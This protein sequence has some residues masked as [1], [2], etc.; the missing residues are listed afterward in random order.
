MKTSVIVALVAA[1]TIF[2]CIHAAN[3]R[4]K[5]D[6]SDG[7]S[8]DFSTDASDSATSDRF[9]EDSVDG[10]SFLTGGSDDDSSDDG[11]LK[12]ILIEAEITTGGSSVVDG[13]DDDNKIPSS[14]DCSNDG[15]SDRLLVSELD[16]DSNGDS[17]NSDDGDSGD[18]LSGTVKPAPIDG[19]TDESDGFD[20]SSLGWW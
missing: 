3:L 1:A 16:T 13:G 9:L 5:V 12:R 8:R 19:S 10:S 17:D 18:Y 11:F 6:V 2:D 15:S 20:K 4:Q 14:T 7:D